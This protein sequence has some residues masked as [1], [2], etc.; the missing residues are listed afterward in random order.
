MAPR[1]Y[2]LLPSGRWVW[3]K[4]KMVRVVSTGSR[5]AS[6]AHSMVGETLDE[7]PRPQGRPVSVFYISSTKVSRYI[8]RLLDE[9]VD[10]IMVITPVTKS[11]Y[12]VE[13]YGFTRRDV[14]RV[15][16]IAESMKAL[17]AIKKKLVVSPSS[18]Q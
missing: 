16:E 12:C 7:Q 14:A 6:V 4:G 1:I 17:R 15:K 18:Q 13:L 2:V 10:G 11:I 9:D 5:R 3:V 8:I